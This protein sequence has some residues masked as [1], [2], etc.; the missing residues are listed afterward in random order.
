ML[1]CAVWAKQS[2]FFDKG[3]LGLN[4]EDFRSEFYSYWNFSLDDRKEAVLSL[5][6]AQAEK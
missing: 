3:E 1:G 4:L 6:D 5:L 2:I